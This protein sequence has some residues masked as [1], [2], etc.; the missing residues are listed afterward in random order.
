MGMSLTVRN[1]TRD[2]WPETRNSRESGER[3]VDLVTRD[4]KPSDIMTLRAFEN[5]IMVDMLWVDQRT[6]SFIFLHST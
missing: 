1:F 5:A 6:Q 3:I 2:K 4:L